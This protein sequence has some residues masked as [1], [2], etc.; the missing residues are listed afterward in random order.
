VPQKQRRFSSSCSFLVKNAT[1][2]LRR[3]VASEN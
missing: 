1:K 2:M 3:Y